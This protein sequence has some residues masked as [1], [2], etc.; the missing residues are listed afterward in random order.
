MR[1][2]LGHHSPEAEDHVLW[3]IG[4]PVLALEER[5]RL[6]P[7]D[8]LRRHHINRGLAAPGQGDGRLAHGVHPALSEDLAHRLFQGL[9]R[10]RFALGDQGV[11]GLP[12]AKPTVKLKG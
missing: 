5:G 9:P 1:A 11:H 2:G 7:V 8:G 12:R 3:D 10:R 4:L 6:D